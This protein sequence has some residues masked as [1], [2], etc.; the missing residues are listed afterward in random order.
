[1]SPLAA[2]AASSCVAISL[3]L[4]LVDSLMCL[5]S[6]NW[7]EKDGMAAKGNGTSSIL[8]FLPSVA[9]NSMA[10]CLISGL[11]LHIDL[12][13]ESSLASNALPL[14]HLMWE[15]VAIAFKASNPGDA[16]L[17]VEFVAVGWGN[18]L[19]CPMAIQ[20]TYG[21]MVSFLTFPGSCH[22]HVGLYFCPNFA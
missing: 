17:M 1:M 16:L 2:F 3:P 6:S 12:Q 14:E 19:H 9:S 15:E 18:I 10:A 21:L 7:L 22:F 13:R 8:A 11:C 20:N 4:S 5:S